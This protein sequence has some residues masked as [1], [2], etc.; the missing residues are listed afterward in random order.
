MYSTNICWKKRDKKIGLKHGDDESE[1]SVISLHLLPVSTD[2]RF[3]W[4]Y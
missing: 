3:R 1:Y 2:D 4:N